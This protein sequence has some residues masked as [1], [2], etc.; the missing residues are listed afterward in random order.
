[1]C[2]DAS[3]NV[4]ARAVKDYC[5]THDLSH[6]SFREGDLVTVRRY[7]S[8]CTLP[9][10]RVV[11]RVKGARGREWAIWEILRIPYT[12]VLWP[13]LKSDISLES[14]CQPLF[15]TITDRRL[16]YASL[17]TLSAVHLMKIITVQL[18]Q[19]S[20]SLHL[21]G[22]GHHLDGFCWFYSIW[23]CR[24]VLRSIRCDLSMA[25]HFI[26]W[27]AI[28]LWFQHSGTPLDAQLH[29]A[30]PDST[31]LDST[32]WVESD[33]AVW[34]LSRRDSTQ[35]R[36]PVAHR[37]WLLKRC[38]YVCVCLRRDNS[39]VQNWDWINNW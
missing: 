2:S 3:S 16:D 25:S 33:R 7:Y 11:E 39:V 15:Y 28:V 5:N 23:D 36:R 6:I 14:C 26:L 20:K 31:Q 1:M 4:R 30:R 18:Q 17:A 38:M 34:T 35:L 37:K 32:S 10:T 9:D 24:N 19:Q 29:T 13:T 22:N 12:P 21:T 27:S 8:L